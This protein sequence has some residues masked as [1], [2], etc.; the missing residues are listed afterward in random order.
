MVGTEGGVLTIS[1]VGE[2]FLPQIE[3]AP[4]LNSRL[5]LNCANFLIDTNRSVGKNWG[6]GV[7][8]ENRTR[9]GNLVKVAMRPLHHTNTASEYW[10]LSSVSDWIL[11]WNVALVAVWKREEDFGLFPKSSLSPT[12]RSNAFRMEWPT[13]AVNRFLEISEARKSWHKF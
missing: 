7:G 5:L 13:P 6:Y 1:G 10:A 11:I 4:S 8:D 3:R 2:V 9:A 12:P